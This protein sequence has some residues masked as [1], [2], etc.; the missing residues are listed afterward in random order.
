MVEYVMLAPFPARTPAPSNARL[1]N[2][3]LYMSVTWPSASIPP[4]V[5]AS[6]AELPNTV[7]CVAFTLPSAL[8]PPP[9]ADGE[10]RNPP[11]G[12][13]QWWTRVRWISTLP[14]EAMHPPRLTSS[15]GLVGSWNPLATVTSCRRSVPVPVWRKMRKVPW[16]SNIIA[17]RPR[18]MTV[19]LLCGTAISP[20][21][22]KM[23][24]HES[25]RRSMMS[26]LS[27]PAT[28]LR[29]LPAP[30]SL[31]LATTRV[32]AL[33]AP[34][35]VQ[36][37]ASSTSAPKTG[38]GVECAMRYMTLLPRSAPARVPSAVDTV[39]TP[40]P[41]AP[42]ELHPATPGGRRIQTRTHSVLRRACDERSGQQADSP[43]LGHSDRHRSMSG[44]PL[45]ARSGHSSRTG[46]IR[47]SSI[48]ARAWPLSAGPRASS[49]SPPDA[50]STCRT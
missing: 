37:P 6:L 25:E 7:L 18:A 38:A 28:A 8:M 3:W 4:P 33:V 14:S 21:V 30:L 26:P 15:P 39:F 27:A 32:A 48:S 40:V 31:Q 49:P 10:S 46:C 23:R 22:N 34:T 45:S 1:L 5:E 12:L 42:R 41:C 24:V 13:W 50:S 11:A 16:P 36:V 17:S 20:V 29:R 44:S 2:T 9:A 19:R 43:L 47:P 35:G